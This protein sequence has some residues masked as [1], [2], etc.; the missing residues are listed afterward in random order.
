MSILQDPV[1]A[2]E[3][4]DWYLAN[5]DSETFP[6]AFTLAAG[7]LARQLVEQILFVLCFYSGMPRQRFLT[8][9]AADARSLKVAGQLIA[10]LDTKDT[11]GVPYWR[12]ARE[13]SPRVR[14][15]ARAPRTLRAWVKRLNAPSH[16]EI[17]HRSVDVSFLRRLTERVRPLLDDKDKYLVLMALNEINSRGA[18][19]A[20]IGDD[21]ECTPGF[22]ET[23]TVTASNLVVGPNGLPSLHTPALSLQV[24]PA[25]Q[26]PSGRWPHRPVLFVGAHGFTMGMRIVDTGG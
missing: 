23:V 9:K 17:R 10:A 4:I 1:A 7:N 6:G 2:V 11:E 24:L 8:K 22:V 14:K 13:R 21:A 15:F 16:Y 19:E 3:Q 20:T 12:R 5:R 25:D 18:M 26:P